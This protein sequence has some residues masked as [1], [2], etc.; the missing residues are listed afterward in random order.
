MERNK[1]NASEQ[2]LGDR[3]IPTQVRSCAFQVEDN[4]YKDE[5]CK[6]S[7]EEMLEK[8]ILGPRDFN[9]ANKIMNFG[10]PQIPKNSG[11]GTKTNVGKCVGKENDPD[12]KARKISQKPYKILDAPN[13]QDDFYLN[14][15]DWSD[16]NQIAVALDS[17]IYLWSG[18]SSNACKLYEA[19]NMSDYLCSVSF[20]D[21]SKIAVG[22]SMGQIQIFDICKLKKVNKF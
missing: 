18:C 10:K 16:N 15:I 2:P 22:N 14:L 5:V 21:D 19:T 7:Y 3:F 8:N 1:E 6:T 11:K 4:F 20:C 13:L 17:S 12:K 9:F